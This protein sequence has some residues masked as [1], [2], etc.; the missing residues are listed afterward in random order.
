[1]VSTMTGYFLSGLHVVLLK[2]K[3]SRYQ[4]SFLPCVAGSAL[5]DIHVAM[6]ATFYCTV[7]FCGANM[8]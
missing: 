7:L 5:A 6:T 4:L 2:F 8:E 1:M 3:L